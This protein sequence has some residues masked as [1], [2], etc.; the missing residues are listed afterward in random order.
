MFVACVKCEENI[1]FASQ[2]T[3]S[4]FHK[5]SFYF[6]FLLS[7]HTHTT[8]DTLVNLLLFSKSY[9][10]N[11]MGRRKNPHPQRAV[12]ARTVLKVARDK[13]EEV[14][15][16]EPLVLCSRIPDEEDDLEANHHQIQKEEEEE[17]GEDDDVERLWRIMCVPR[18]D[19]VEQNQTRKDA[20]GVKRK[21]GHECDVCE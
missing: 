14:E 9:T 15:E 19:V 3:F 5:I 13:E 7:D 8:C 20:K 1:N 16:E 6:F 10:N 2:N 21:R 4:R 17:E 18:D 11:T 12:N